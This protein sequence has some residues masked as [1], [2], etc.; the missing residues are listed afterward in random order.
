MGS[1]LLHEFNPVEGYIPCK[2]WLDLAV[3]L[4]CDAEAESPPHFCKGQTCLGE[5]LG[6]INSRK[7][8]V[9]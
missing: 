1:M 4:Q 3:N 6:F 8:Y 7:V 9:V 2:F 5:I